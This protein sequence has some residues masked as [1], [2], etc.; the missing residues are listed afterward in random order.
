MNKDNFWNVGAVVAI[1]A[2]IAMAAVSISNKNTIEV[3][4]SVQSTQSPALG[5]ALTYSTA[6]GQ[7]E[8]YN[9]LKEVVGDFGLSSS[10]SWNPA[11]IA[12][13]TATDDAGLPNTST[14][15][16]MSGA[17][18]G[19]LVL[20]SFATTTSFDKWFTTGKV[21]AADTVM[22]SL[23]NTD[24]VDLNLGAATLRVRVIP[25]SLLSITTSTP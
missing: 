5:S 12:T 20:T 6:Q 22:V 17:T 21:I 25:Y 4:E 2:L 24:N 3:R 11:N 15:L 7:L 10:T 18:V 13:S 23:W 16:T 9:F 19:D 8:T 14:T 1:V